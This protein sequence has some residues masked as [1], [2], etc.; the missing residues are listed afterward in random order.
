MPNS[1]NMEKERHD[2]TE[3]CPHLVPLVVDDLIKV[4]E[5]V[6]S[7]PPGL[8]GV[9]VQSLEDAHDL[10]L[11]CGTEWALLAIAIWY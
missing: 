11:G 8:C 4:V 2:N 7:E 6:K 9:L 3:N 5:V 1:I 10:P